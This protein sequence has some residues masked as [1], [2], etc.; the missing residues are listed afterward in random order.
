MK[1]K[2]KEVRV[3]AW[4]EALGG[5]DTEGACYCICGIFYFIFRGF[6][7]LRRNSWTVLLCSNDGDV[8]TFFLFLNKYLSKTFFSLI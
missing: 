5:R 8:V 2:K 1:T 3:F 4:E 7:L 6:L